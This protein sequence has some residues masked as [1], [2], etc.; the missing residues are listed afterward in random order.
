MV[1]KTGS[2]LFVVIYNFKSKWNT[3]IIFWSQDTVPKTQPSLHMCPSSTLET[4]YDMRQPRVEVGE[5][6]EA[7]K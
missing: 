3:Y 7:R 5:G 2:T 6:G 4:A 1:W